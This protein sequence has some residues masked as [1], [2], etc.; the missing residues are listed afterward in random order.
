MVE[1]ACETSSGE[2]RALEQFSLAC[3]P[4]AHTLEQ[5]G[6]EGIL[7]GG[8]TPIFDSHSHKGAAEV[9]IRIRKEKGLALLR[10]TPLPSGSQ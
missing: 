10:E 4:A 1:R 6:E 3:Q 7:N 8:E 2:K 9:G 5:V